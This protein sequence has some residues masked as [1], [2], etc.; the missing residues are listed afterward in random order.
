MSNKNIIVGD[1]LTRWNLTY[2]MIKASREKKISVE[3]QW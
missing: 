1:V 3:G 2:D